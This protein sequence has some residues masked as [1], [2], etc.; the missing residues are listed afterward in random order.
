MPET[1]NYVFDHAELAEILVKKLEIHDGLWG[2]YVEFGLRAANVPTSPDGKSALPAAINFVQKIG[3]QRFE[4]PNNL[5]VD[6][7]QVNPKESPAKDAK[8]KAPHK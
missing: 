1:K 5:T 7:A 4:G 8:P 6:A 3:I 2:I